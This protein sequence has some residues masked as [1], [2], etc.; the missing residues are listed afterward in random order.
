M[1][2]AILGRGMFVCEKLPMCDV[3]MDMHIFIASTGDGSISAGLSSGFTA[4]GG[5]AY[6]GSALN[7]AYY[8]HQIP[9]P[10]KSK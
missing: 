2:Q 3:A 5:A 7:C 6:A 9:H 8:T 4:T 10:F 1:G